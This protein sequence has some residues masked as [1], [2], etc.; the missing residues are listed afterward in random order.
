MKLKNTTIYSW[1][2]NGVRAVL[3]KGFMD[4]LDKADPDIVCLQEIKADESVFPQK[5]HDKE[6]YHIYVNSAKRKGYAGTAVLSTKKP[7]SILT[8][9]GE[10][11]FDSEGRIQV[12]EF[13]DFYLVNTYF[14][15]SQPELKRLDF[16]IEFNQKYLEFVKNLD[17]PVIL[18]GDFNFAH[19]EIDLANPK[20]NQKN[21]GFTP[22]ERAYGDELIENGFVD[23]WRETHP[24]EV[25]YSWWTYRFGARNRNVGWRID[26]FWLEKELMKKLK[27]AEIH[28]DVMGS[29][30]CPVSVSF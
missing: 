3:R 5:L 23:S 15:N 29:D 26:Y 22:E 24:E 9:I 14:P 27:K 20:S 10:E 11:K 28:N 2:V 8:G 21:A 17:K 6:G 18:T 25:K 13:D 16:K 7:L 12:L 1:N 19:R 30:H 4:W